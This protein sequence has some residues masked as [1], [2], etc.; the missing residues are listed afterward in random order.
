MTPDVLCRPATVSDMRKIAQLMQPLVDQNILLGK[1]MVVLYESV[2]QFIVAEIDG[3]IVGYGALHVMWE[4][5]GEVRTL[6]VIDR[7][8][9]KG[10]GHRLLTELEQHALR[11]GLSQL[12]S[13]T[14]EVEFFARHGWR[15]LPDAAPV[16]AADV[17]AELL[18]SPDEGIAE[19]LDL[20]HVKPNTL[21]NTR[22]LKTLRPAAAGSAPAAA[23]AA[24][25]SAPA[26]VAGSTREKAE[27]ARDERLG[28][29]D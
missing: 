23:G 5:M 9:G 19:M 11:L 4:H 24:A 8:R 26:A 21:G 2:Q 28:D 29:E 17:Y 7:V 25:G 6:G 22:M 27:R 20:A 14:F 13:L 16:V 18:R 15:I 10:V 3:E 1:E 12:V